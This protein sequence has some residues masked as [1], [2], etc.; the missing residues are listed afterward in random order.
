M[1]AIPLTG[2]EGKLSVS[3][4]SLPLTQHL[5]CLLLKA[6]S[7]L[8]PWQGWAAGRRLHQG[9]PVIAPARTA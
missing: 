8:A 2:W 9:V 3:F 1:P 4:D 7:L 5:A 6:G